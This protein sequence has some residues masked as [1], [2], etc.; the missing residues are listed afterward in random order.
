MLQRMLKFVS[1]IVHEC[2]FNF[3][4]LLALTLYL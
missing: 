2:L 3:N 1:G 4:I